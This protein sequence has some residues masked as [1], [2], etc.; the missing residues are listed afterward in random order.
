M[1]LHELTACIYYKIAIERGLRG[2][3]PDGEHIT[4]IAPS[5]G[6]SDARNPNDIDD[7]EAEESGELQDSEL[8]EIMRYICL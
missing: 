6:Y 1:S 8:D 2:C 7:E 3:D 4:H 5:G